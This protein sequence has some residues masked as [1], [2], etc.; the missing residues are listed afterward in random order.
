MNGRVPSDP[1]TTPT[2]LVVKAVP[3]SLA[4][5]NPREIIIEE[6]ITQFTKVSRERRLGIIL[7]RFH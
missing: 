3:A 1:L 7:D 6:T 5:H 4:V 2:Y